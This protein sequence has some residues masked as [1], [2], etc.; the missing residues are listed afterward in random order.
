MRK[1]DV[2]GRFLHKLVNDLVTRLRSCCNQV[3]VVCLTS[4]AHVKCYLDQSICICK[5]PI[6]KR[7]ISGVR[8]VLHFLETSHHRQFA[9]ITLTLNGGVTFAPKHTTL[10]LGA[11]EHMTLHLH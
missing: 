8:V 4:V 5:H 1:A 3:C 6:C 7:I 2:I 9:R 11:G 10:Q